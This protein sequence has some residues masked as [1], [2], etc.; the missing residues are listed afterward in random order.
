MVQKKAKRIS[1]YY[2]SQGWTIACLD[3]CSIN[4]TPYLTRGWALK[5]NRPVMKTN[6]MRERFHILGARTR[7][8]FLFKFIT[9]QNQ[10]S[11]I[12]FVRRVLK[13]HPRLA[14]F[15]D[16]APCTRAKPSNS[17]A[18]SGGV[19]LPLRYFSAS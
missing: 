19:L 18:P 9:R 17:F 1:T 6:Y 7:H 12:R 16:N 10:K 5:G 15:L 14:I 13:Q 8:K 4:I 11:F 3:E 2:R